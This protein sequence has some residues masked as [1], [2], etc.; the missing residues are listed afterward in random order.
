MPMFLQR[1]YDVWSM[2]Q[3]MHRHPSKAPVEAHSFM[4]AEG[5]DPPPMSLERCVELEPKARLSCCA[6]KATV[7]LS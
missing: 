7:C 1:G 6:A 3:A 2:R 4:Q 5:S